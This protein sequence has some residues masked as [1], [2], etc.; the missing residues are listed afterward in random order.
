MSWDNSSNSSNANPNARY[1]LRRPVSTSPRASTY[2]V[3]KDGITGTFGGRLHGG[4]A[5][6]DPSKRCSVS[7]VRQ[8]EKSPKS[9]LCGHR[10]FDSKAANLEIVTAFIY[11]FC[12]DEGR[13]FCIQKF[14]NLYQVRRLIHCAYWMM[15]IAAFETHFSRVVKNI[16]VAY[17]VIR[18]WPA[19]V[20]EWEKADLGGITTFF[21]QQRRFC[22][23]EWFID[24]KR[25]WIGKCMEGR[26]VW[27]GDP[28]IAEW[29][30]PKLRRE[31]RRKY[32]ELAAANSV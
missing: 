28:N 8:I 24:W 6:Y 9:C 10:I 25:W 15:A 27:S 19:C 22:S 26:T 7:Y 11:I 31:D 29:R 1:R 13:K 14:V 23:M 18:L 17:S 4:M 3:P 30:A 20:W 16:L 12:S 2:P 21:F 32:I 5:R